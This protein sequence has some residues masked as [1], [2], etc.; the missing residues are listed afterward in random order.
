MIFETHAHYD[1]EAFDSDREELLSSM[2]ENGIGHI[3]NVS[4]SLDSLDRTRELMEQ[5]PFIYGAMGL[6]PDEV[7]DMNEAV[8]QKLRDYCRLENSGGR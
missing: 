3:V 6:H 4:A 5:Y 7:G 8:M 2:Q 1:D